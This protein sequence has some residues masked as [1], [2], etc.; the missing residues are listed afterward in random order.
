MQRIPNVLWPRATAAAIVVGGGA[1]MLFVNLPGHLE[2]D[3]VRQL[4]EGRNGVYSNWHPPVMSWLLGLGDGIIPGAAAFVVFNVLLA[5]GTLLSVLW[6][7]PR[8]GWLSVGAAL[9]CVALPQLF[10]FPA[11]VW[12]DM[13]FAE[14]CVAGFVLLAHAAMYWQCVRLR[15]VLLLGAVLLCA[16]AALT[17]QSGLL[18]L[19]CAA[20]AL[21]LIAGRVVGRKAGLAYGVGFLLACAGATL[22]G[23]A[24]LQL[25]ASKALGAV[26]Q[27]EDLQLYDMA[28]MLQRQ[29]ALEL[30]SLRR[31]APALEERMRN[32]GA[33]LYT[34]I[35]HD[36][37]TDDPVIHGLI[38]GSVSAV[39]RQWQAL[40]LAHPWTYLQV[41]GEDFSWLFLSQH[42]SECLIYEVG[43]SGA[44]ADL[45][46]AHLSPRYDG[47]DQWLDEGYGQ[48]LIGT[49]ALSHPAFALVGAISLI[50]M[51]W[52]R[53]PADLAFAGLM[54]A[55]LFYTLSF[56]VISIACQYRYLYAIDMS[57]IAAAFYLLTDWRP[58][59]R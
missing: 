48:R 56:F 42:P 37:L 36:R 14:S 30:A 28:G 59:E 1:L 45:R 31:D 24:L 12:K 26:E 43:V 7:V 11:I 6:L 3:S 58:V 13:L 16:L 46:A 15:V 23:N 8:P 44:P 17:R 39:G 25:R 57:A 32:V 40:I 54:F 4:L 52:R 51:L 35:G 38:I 47:R 55:T 10:L 21:G 41:R 49:P 22:G 9:I 50:A 33:K 53:R 29:P 19:P 5:F 20:A 27:I 18:I 34:P 2:F